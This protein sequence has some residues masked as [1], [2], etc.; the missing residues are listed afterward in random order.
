[1]LQ[2]LYRLLSIHSGG[3][4]AREIIVFKGSMGLL[5]ISLAI[6]GAVANFPI[7][8]V[9]SCVFGLDYL[10]YRA[11]MIEKFYKVEEYG[12]KFNI[13]KLLE[14]EGA[15]RPITEQELQNP[16]HTEETEFILENIPNLE[17]SSFV[18][19]IGC[20]SGV[21]TVGL[22]KRGISVIS[23]DLTTRSLKFTDEIAKR[24]GYATNRIL[25]DAQ[26]LP[27]KSSCLNLVIASSV[28]EHLPN[29]VIGFM[30]ALR[31]LEHE[32][33]AIFSLPSTHSPVYS[34]CSFLFNPIILLER[35]IS[36]KLPLVLPKRSKFVYLGE[37]FFQRDKRFFCDVSI[38]R[39]YDQKT[40]RN[41]F[42]DLG[43]SVKLVGFFSARGARFTLGR[44]QNLVNYHPYLAH[45]FIVF[46]EKLRE[47]SII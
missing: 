16:P 32:G 1:M 39:Q 25:A 46:G 24:E 18:L 14:A 8:L 7:F 36:W 41:L 26:Y 30:E 40:I 9:A 29:D 44:L 21:L 12:K 19:D 5:F 17:K 38:H 31:V 27:F 28:I 11:Y 42:N 3:Y 15:Y 10:L 20:G 33:R 47:R 23:L 45:I 35:L 13:S 22:L 43:L 34:L 6:Y 37:L 4:I 2:E